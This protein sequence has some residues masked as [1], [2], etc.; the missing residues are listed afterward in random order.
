MLLTPKDAKQ[1]VAERKGDVPRGR[2]G[3]CEMWSRS[4]PDD[5]AT[6][7][8]GLRCDYPAPNQRRMCENRPAPPL[9]TR[10]MADV[11][12]PSHGPADHPPHENELSRW[13]R[14]TTDANGDPVIAWDEDAHREWCEKW[15]PP[16][17]DGNP[18]RLRRARGFRERNLGELEL[19]VVLGGDG[20]GVCQ[21]IV[22]EHDDEVYV[23]VLI[24]YDEYGGPASLD[25]TDCPVRVWLDRPLGER[26]VIDVDS[27]EEL[28]LYTPPYLNNVT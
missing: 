17:P 22:E 3:A 7:L 25:Y 6:S 8:T 21:V 20:V 4:V 19:R 15:A 2:S 13:E 18:R 27:D 11:T 1:V 16:C 28:P 14:W 23:R 9:W 12:S 26:A 24:H 10:T 5:A